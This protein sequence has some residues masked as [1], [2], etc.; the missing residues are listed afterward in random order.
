MEHG[1]CTS[2]RKFL[3]GRHGPAFA[4]PPSPPEDTDRRPSVL[5]APGLLEQAHTLIREPDETDAEF[6]LRHQL[7]HTLLDHAK[8][9]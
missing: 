2:L 4:R 1:P 6:E 5:V 3:Y 8:Q 9:G 7:F